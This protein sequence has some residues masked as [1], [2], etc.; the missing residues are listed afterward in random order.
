MTEEKERA[1]REL[2]RERILEQIKP[3]AEAFGIKDI[4]YWPDEGE[5]LV[6]DGQKI[7]CGGNSDYAVVKEL[8][9]YLFVKRKI[10]DYYPNGERL[11]KKMTAYWR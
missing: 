6:L 1:Y 8:I 11:K 3:M 2:K 10:Y 5:Y 7:A 9:Q 4:D